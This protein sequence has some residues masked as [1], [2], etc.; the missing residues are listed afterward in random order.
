MGIT[1]FEFKV[2][3]LLE[4]KMSKYKNSIPRKAVVELIEK[5]IQT[6]NTLSKEE[7]LNLPIK[8]GDSLYPICWDHVADEW[9]IDD[10]PERV[11]EVGTKYFFLSSCYTDPE[12][13]DE[14]HTYNE[15]GNT[16]FL[17]HE[18]AEAAVAKLR[19]EQNHGK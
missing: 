3:G 4:G 12:A 14:Y 16:F 15:I 2:R 13:P 7:L 11:N 19:E 17:T 10:K 8:V 9:V 18:D 5:T 1:E 6:Y